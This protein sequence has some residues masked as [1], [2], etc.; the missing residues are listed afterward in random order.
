MR[1]IKI[2]HVLVLKLADLKVSLIENILDIN[3][4]SREKIWEIK[5]IL[6]INLINNS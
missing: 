4:R 6:D 3:P 2:H 1:I 5:K